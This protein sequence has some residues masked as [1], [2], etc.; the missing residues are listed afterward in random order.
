[1][2]FAI[3]RPKEK[4]QGHGLSI[5]DNLPKKKKLALTICNTFNSLFRIELEYRHA[6]SR[7]NP[8]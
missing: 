5:F 7:K 2:L 3:K 8:R 1:M 4:L 6:S